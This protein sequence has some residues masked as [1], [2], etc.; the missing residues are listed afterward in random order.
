MASGGG[1]RGGDV[2]SSLLETKRFSL[3]VPD[4]SAV[5]GAKNRNV[6]SKH[7]KTWFNIHQIM[8]KSVFSKG[9]SRYPFIN[10]MFQMCCYLTI[11]PK[12]VNKLLMFS[13]VWSRSNSSLPL[14]NHL[15]YLYFFTCSMYFACSL[16]FTHSMPP[17]FNFHSRLNMWMYF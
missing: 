2:T 13:S 12:C 1:G 15:D 9:L 10:A 7:R 16:V 4:V 17:K 8:E 3:N 6:S 5:T 14:I 11:N